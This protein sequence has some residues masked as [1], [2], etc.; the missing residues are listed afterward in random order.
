MIDVDLHRGYIVGKL[1]GAGIYIG[2]AY[3]VTVIIQEDSIVRRRRYDRIRC[4]C[5]DEEGVAH[6]IP[7]PYKSGC[8]HWLPVLQHRKSYR[9]VLAIVGSGAGGPYP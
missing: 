8:I 2:V 5:S 4:R 9:D 3:R 1:E 6:I 7:R